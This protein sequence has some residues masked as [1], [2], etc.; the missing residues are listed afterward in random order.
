M[1][2]RSSSPYHLRDFDAYKWFESERGAGGDLYRF[3]RAVCSS[4]R[5]IASIPA[6]P[7]WHCTD[8]VAGR[9]ELRTVG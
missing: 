5:S 4:F 9:L 6:L 3:L 8:A 2:P 1:K 7:A